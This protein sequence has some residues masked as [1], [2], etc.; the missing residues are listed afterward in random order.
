M[1]IAIIGAG[2][3]G[4]TAAYELREAAHVDVFEAADRIGGKLFTVPFNDGPTDMGAEAF[5]ARRADATDF[6]KELELADAFVAPSPLRPLLYSGSELRPLPLGGVMGIPSSPEPVKDIVSADTI[7]RIA[8]EADAEPIKWEVGEDRSIGK[9]V[10]ERYGAEVADRIVS[11]LLGGVY[12]CQ[13]DDLGVRAT[14]PYLAAALDELADSGKPVTLSAAVALVEKRFTPPAAQASSAPAEGAAQPPRPAVFQAFRDG[15]ATLYEA[16]AEKSGANIHLEVF[17]AGVERTKDGKL[18]VSGMGVDKDTAPYDHVIIA[19][20]APTTAR[21][22]TKVAPA[23]AEELKKVKLASSAVV[24]MKIDSD[25]GLPEASGILVAAD[26]PGVHVKAFTLSSN[27]WPH[28]KER[29][30]N[31]A[32]IRASFGRFGEDAITREEEDVLV[33]YALDD[34]KTIT[35]FDAREAGVSEIYTQRWFGGIPRFD[36]HHLAT[37]AAVREQLATVDGI[38]VVGA[39]AAGVGVPAVIADARSTARSLR[40]A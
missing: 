1:R 25:A 29:V 10:R 2:L 16:L 19:T 17:V 32:L 3:A 31:G 8:A 33:D 37:I 39:W 23:A 11:S 5:L 20:P 24:G 35:G 15:Y 38:E 12:S 18:N 13:A 28:L 40:N 34:L 9:L 21:L 36:E 22:L 26:Q 14:V 30:G 7:E 6:F 27:K 4:L